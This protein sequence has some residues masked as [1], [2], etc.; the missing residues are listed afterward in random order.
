MSDHPVDFNTL[1]PPS[2]TLA[3]SPARSPEDVHNAQ[4]NVADF[5][6]SLGLPPEEEAP[7]LIELLQMLG[8]TPA[9]R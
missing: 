5:V 8:L 2:H 1:A 7:A 6:K 3:S 4:L 9:D